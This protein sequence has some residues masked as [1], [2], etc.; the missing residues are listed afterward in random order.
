[1]T[2]MDQEGF[3]PA[4]LKESVERRY[5]YYKARTI[6]HPILKNAYETIMSIIR[7]PA[8]KQIVMVI[9]PPRSGKT[10]LLEWLES[11]IKYYWAQI[12]ASDPGRIPIASIEV[13][14]RDTL[15]P[16]WA[17]IYERIL[18][19]LEEHLTDQKIIYGDVMYQ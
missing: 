19:A 11:E 14:S 10:F 7:E 12:Q 1:M 3:D 6:A 9:G 8:G 13:P 16:N 17:L 2:N 18:K 15:K 4:I 5:E